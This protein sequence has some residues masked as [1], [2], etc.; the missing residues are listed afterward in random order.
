[1]KFAE[2]CLILTKIS[3]CLA[4]KLNNILSYITKIMPKMTAVEETHK[5]NFLLLDP[6]TS[7]RMTKPC[8]YLSFWAVS[9]SKRVEESQKASN[10]FRSFDDG[11]ASVPAQ[12]DG[13][14]N[15]SR[16]GV[17]AE[18][19]TIRLFTPSGFPESA[20]FGVVMRPNA[21]LRWRIDRDF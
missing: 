10:F 3:H 18:T 5:T 13:V 16:F 20:T 12:D 6:S 7:L 8:L 15:I 1:M 4:Q 21:A 11:T 9:D 19:L 14:A 17:Y 2:N